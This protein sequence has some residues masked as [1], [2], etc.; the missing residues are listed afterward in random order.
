MWELYDRLIAG[1]PDDWKAEEIVRGSSYCY[2]RS[3]GGI[4]ISEM[5]SYDYRKPTIT[6][7]MEGAPLKEL[8]GCIRSWN[9]VEA[10]VGHAAINAYYNHREI[11]RNAGVLIGDSMHVEDRIYDPFIMGQNEV[12]GKK[13]T[14]LGHFPHIT[15]LLAPICE[16][17]IIAGDYPEYDDYPACSVEYLLPESDFVYISSVAFVDKRM[18]RLLE[19]AKNAG[20]VTIV[21]PSTTLAPIL[22]ESGV[23]DLSGFIV[24]DIERAMRIVKG[25]ENGKFFSVGQ[26]VA[27]KSTQAK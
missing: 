26:K 21:G 3:N 14:V 2:V 24:K 27:F 8:A 11:A 20:K 16:M 13:V 10:S 5:K 4:G 18:P 23:A 22:F 6:R 17:R 12:R 25:A 9:F 1:I 7:N 15:T 19:L